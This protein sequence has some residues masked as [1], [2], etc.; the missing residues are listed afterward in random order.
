ELAVERERLRAAL[1]D[2]GLP[3]APSEANFLWLPIGEAALGFAEQC[4]AAGVLVRPYPGSGVRVTVGTPEAHAVLC[5]VA[6][7]SEAACAS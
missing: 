5:A 6:A 1:L 2:A 7:R 3:V 4:R